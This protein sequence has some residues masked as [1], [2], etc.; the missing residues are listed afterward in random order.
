MKPQSLQREGLAHGYPIETDA[1]CARQCV[2]G[3]RLPKQALRH[4]R[5]SRGEWEPCFLGLSK[6]GRESVRDAGLPHLRGRGATGETGG[7]G[8]RLQSHWEVWPRATTIPKPRSPGSRLWSLKPQ[9]PPAERKAVRF[10][11][12]SPGWEPSSP[13]P[14]DPADTRN[15]RT[16][17]RATKR[18]PVPGL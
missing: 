3:L 8:T 6:V 13:P 2:A 18:V 14:R 4:Q 17:A 7:T 10:R 9:W 1:F 15:V 16:P 5:R 12:Q 11:D